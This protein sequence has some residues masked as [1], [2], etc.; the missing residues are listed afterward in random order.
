MKDKASPRRK[1]LTEQVRETLARQIEAQQLKPGDRLPTEREMIE[2]YGVS[3]TVVRD[4]I[5]RLRASGLVES[6]QGSGVYVLAPEITVV[7]DAAA[8]TLASIVE[9]LEV[10]M[11]IEIEAARLAATRGSPIQ[12]A[13]IGEKC[14]Q[15]QES[16][17]EGSEAAD[18]AFHLAIASATNNRRFVEF[19]EF[20]G[21]RTIPR[22][23]LREVHQL[24]AHGPDYVG[25]LQVEHRAIRDAIFARDT[26]AAGQA[27]RR[28]LQTSQERYFRLARSAPKDVSRHGSV[29]ARLA[30]E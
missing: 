20:L 22:S 19:F 12:L 30:P 14:E 23:Q 29:M 6:R 2:A 10:R 27:M 17:P 13:D 8:A 9:T 16:S 11:A 4:A 24:P 1:S 15:M 21:P 3:R 5:A 28:H 26:D 7:G 25:R 18:L